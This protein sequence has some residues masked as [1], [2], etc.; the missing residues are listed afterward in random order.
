YQASRDCPG[1]DCVVSAILDNTRIL[2]DPRRS[3]AA[4]L[5]ALK[6]VVHFIA[7]VHQPL[8]AGAAQSKGGN[9]IQVRVPA[10]FIPPWADGNPGSNLHSVWDSGLL[11][12]SGR[13]EAEHLGHLL[14]LP[15]A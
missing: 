5:Q 12:S 15:L 8:H 10:P 13:G 11:Y 14:A 4:R 2:A 1:G 9:T 3:D 7:D 6:F